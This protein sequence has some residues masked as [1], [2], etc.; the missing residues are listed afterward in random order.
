M[1]LGAVKGSGASEADLSSRPSPGLRCS[2]PSETCLNGGKCEVF[3][4]GSEA[5]L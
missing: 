1:S 2:Q 4:N 3:L 5:C